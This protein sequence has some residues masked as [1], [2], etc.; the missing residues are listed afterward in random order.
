MKKLILLRHGHSESKSE[1]G[2][3]ERHLSKKGQQQI[4]S[5]VKYINQNN[6]DTSTIIL[7]SPAKR[8]IETKNIILENLD[9]RYPSKPVENF[10][11]GTMNH[12]I[13]TIYDQDVK[14]KCI[15]AIGHNPIWSDFASYLSSKELFLKTGEAIFLEKEV[16]N[17][18]QLINEKSWNIDKH[19]SH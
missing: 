5:V 18:D 10:Y 9:I 7:F 4:L 17:W 2:D 1:Q 19:L 11:S 14:I 12:V 13:S 16:E 3:K 8:A 6:H 15:L